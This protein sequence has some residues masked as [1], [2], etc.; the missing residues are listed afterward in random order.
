M[1]E[2]PAETAAWEIIIDETL[3]VILTRQPFRLRDSHYVLTSFLKVSPAPASLAERRARRAALADDRVVFTQRDARWLTQMEALLRPSANASKGEVE[4][5]RAQ[6]DRLL[7]K[8]AEAQADPKRDPDLPDLLPY[9]LCEPKLAENGDDPWAWLK[10]R[11]RLQELDDIYRYLHPIPAWL[12]QDAPLFTDIVA[13]DRMVKRADHK[14]DRGRI[15]ISGFRRPDM[16]AAFK[17]V[18]IMSALFR[19]TTIHAVWSQLGVRFVPSEM[20]R[21]QVPT[22]P[23]GARRL[24]IYWLS[25]DGWS[26]RARDKAGGIGAIFDLIAKAGIINPVETV[27]ACTN[28]DDAT[29]DEPR[30]VREHFPSAIIMPHNARGQNRFR[31]FHQLIHCAALNAYTPDIRWMETA[32]GIDARTQRIA[33]TGQEVY[34]TMMRLS[35]REPSSQADVVVVV[36]DKDVAEWLPQWFEPTDQVEVI[37]IDSSGVIRPKGKPGRPRIEHPLTPAER[38]ARRRQRRRDQPGGADKP[39]AP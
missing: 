34:Q 7:A 27:C 25:D 1:T 36:M 16:L 12:S 24:R 33:R 5:A 10:R 21:I 4:Q 6:R 11:I 15:T 20:I 14:P 35:L 23:L 3:E 13:W 30:V 19:H 39:V 22:T 17:R 2:W 31:H 38:Q 32:L 8:Q 28:K 9:Y 37:E 29:E 18:T 26:K